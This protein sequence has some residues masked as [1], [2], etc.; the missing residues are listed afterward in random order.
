MTQKEKRHEYYLSNRDYFLSK[1]SERYYKNKRTK[2]TIVDLDGEEWRIV[3]E[4]YAV[5]NYSRVKSLGNFE[6]LKKDEVVLSEVFRRGYPTVYINGQPTKVS[7]MVAK[8]FP[9]ICGEWFE[10][11]EVHH[12]DHNRDNNLPEN[13]KVLSK[14]EHRKYH[15]QSEITY[16]NKSRAQKK[17]WET[18]SRD[19][20]K[21][22]QPIVAIKDGSIYRI[23][24]SSKAAAEDLGLCESGISNNLK[25]RSQYCGGY[26]F[27]RPCDINKYVKIETR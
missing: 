17:A 25:G 4:H 5:S 23:Y 26:K 15:S 24:D 21:A 12:I 11:C 2:Q 9:E 14:E 19:N 18:R 13:L 8:A 3:Y 16:N 1:A 22:K 10:G 7:V 27:I 20:S 6:H